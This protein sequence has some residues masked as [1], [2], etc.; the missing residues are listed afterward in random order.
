MSVYDL[1]DLSLKSK[2]LLASWARADFHVY[3]RPTSSKW[4]GDGG[5]EGPYFVVTVEI[6]ALPPAEYREE[7]RNLDTAIRR[8]GK[9]IKQDDDQTEK[10]KSGVNLGSDGLPL[11]IGFLAPRAL[12]H[13]RYR[14][15]LKEQ[16]LRGD[17]ARAEGKAKDKALSTRHVGPI[18]DRYGEGRPRPKKSKSK[19]KSKSNKKKV[20][21]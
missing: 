16:T 1:Y 12:W 18:H 10:I 8:I 4:C 21:K 9:R 2:K 19:K 15:I 17:A 13:A 20:K 14:S 5:K 6:R 7:S 3:I 11:N